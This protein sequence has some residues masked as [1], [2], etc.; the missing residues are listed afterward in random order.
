MYLDGLCLVIWIRMYLYGIRWIVPG[1]ID[2]Y[3]PR[4]GPMG[5]EYGTTLSEGAGVIRTGYVVPLRVCLLVAVRCGGCWLVSSSLLASFW[6]RP[7]CLNR[8]WNIIDVVFVGT[9]VHPK[10]PYSPQEHEY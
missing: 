3:G 7:N 5:L 9:G 8:P 6:K 10:T 2:S 4:P 1:Y